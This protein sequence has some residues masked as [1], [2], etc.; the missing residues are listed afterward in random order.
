MTSS[1]C[2]VTERVMPT[3]SHSWNASVPM[4]PVETWPVMQTMGIE[5]MYASHRGV[6]MLVAAGPEVTMATPGTTGYVRVTLGHVSGPLLVTH[7]D[8]ADRAFEKRV[9]GGKNAAAG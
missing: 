2:L 9:V 7:E 6:T 1:L 8:V 5:S 3:V 4:A